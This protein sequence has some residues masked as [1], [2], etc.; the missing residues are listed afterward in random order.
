MLRREDIGA[1]VIEDHDHPRPRD[2]H[3]KRGAPEVSPEVAQSLIDEIRGEIREMKANIM[4]LRSAISVIEPRL[5]YMIFEFGGELQAIRL[6]LEGYIRHS[7]PTAPS[8][9]FTTSIDLE[10]LPSGDIPSSSY[11]PKPNVSFTVED[12]GLDP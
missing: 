12:F 4:F 5:E 2:R 8:T 7:H 9:P 10:H 3:R 11:G 1:T 6:I